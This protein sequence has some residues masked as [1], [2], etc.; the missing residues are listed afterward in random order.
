MSRP[1]RTSGCPAS[2]R[3]DALVLSV[4]VGTAIFLSLM[5]ILLS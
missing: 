4:G 3:A 1:R 5:T 2:S